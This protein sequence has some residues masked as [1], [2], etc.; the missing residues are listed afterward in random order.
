MRAKRSLFWLP[1]VL[2]LVAVEACGSDSTPGRDDDGYA[3]AAPAR[4][5]SPG[6]T[7]GAPGSA[8]APIAAGGTPSSTGGS[9][10]GVAGRKNNGKGGKGGS[11]AGG[12]DAGGGDPGAGGTS[13]G[14]GEAGGPAGGA[15][16]GTTLIGPRALTWYTFQ[17]NTPVNSLFSA[18]GKLLIPYYSVA[19]P[20]TQMVNCLGKKVAAGVKCGT[21]NYGDKLYVDFLK[22]RTMPN[23]KK[24]TGWVELMDYC[25]D[26]NDDGYCYQEDDK[27]NKTVPNVDIYIG[28]F[29]KSGMKP[30][31]DEC[32][33]PAGNGSQP[34]NLSVGTPAA[35]ELVKDYGGAAVGTG[36]CGDRQTAR[37][38]QYGPKAGVPFGMGDKGGT[39]TAC[40]GY[41]GQGTDISD[42]A[43][44]MPGITCAAK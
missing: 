4:A 43:D 24:H 3:G 10:G 39:T 23:G 42:C 25:G 38:Q 17:D 16:S 21:L 40:W 32:G 33:G 1:A 18:S 13:G 15:P 26:Y 22:G 5:G 31:T 14:T 44:C 28:D 37:D 9:D 6:S 36:K 35:A 19:V 27:G 20:Y 8:G 2:S 34:F 11:E 7:A 29:V 12:N 30:G 41:D